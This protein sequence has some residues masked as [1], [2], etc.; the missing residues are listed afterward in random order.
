MVNHQAE[1]LE[2]IKNQY[3]SENF[4]FALGLILNYIYKG[5]GVMAKEKDFYGT[6]YF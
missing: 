3:N 4:E 6:S 2:M 5:L 1:I